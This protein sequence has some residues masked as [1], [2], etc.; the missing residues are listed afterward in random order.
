MYAAPMS[1]TNTKSD[2]DGYGD[3]TIVFTT[4]IEGRALALA[5]DRLGDSDWLLMLC[6]RIGDGLTDLIAHL[7][8]PM[9]ADWKSMARRQGN[10]KAA[11][12]SRHEWL[13]SIADT[14]GLWP[15]K[16]GPSHLTTAIV[17]AATTT[18]LE[19]ATRKQVARR[20]DIWRGEVHPGSAQK[21]GPQKGN[22]HLA[23][24]AKRY[25]ELLQ[26]SSTPKT[27]LVNEHP[28]TSINTV[29]SWL[30]KARER[31][32]LTSDGRG[33]AGGRLTPEALRLIEGDQ[34]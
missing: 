17:R 19:K 1:G 26:T 20:Q 32:L 30:Y 13:L 9:P 27:D 28:G 6:F 10:S 11:G 25:V 4:T 21:S 29:N 2:G 34:Q 33:R 31:G 8:Q 15:P 24:I 23:L 3:R 22:L 14:L 18:E 12:P 16:P 7:I 5:A